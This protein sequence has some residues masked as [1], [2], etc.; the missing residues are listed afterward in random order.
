MA[1]MEQ[2]PAGTRPDGAAG[3]AGARAGVTLRRAADGRLLA[4]VG[5]APIAV[6]VRQCFPW[7]DPDR[8]LSLRDDEDR[9]VALV[10]DPATLDASSRAALHDALGEAGFVL[11]VVRV[12]EVEEEVEI[13]QWV[14]E[15]AQGRRSFQTRLDDWPSRLPGGA[16]VIRDVA[17]DLYRI[18]DPGRMDRESRALL[19]AFVD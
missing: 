19:W 11:D 15:T 3:A 5:G 2:W 13:R 6:R 7:S 8:Q 18:A 14:V 12:V 17:G 4:T 9:E 10:D 1:V 16:L